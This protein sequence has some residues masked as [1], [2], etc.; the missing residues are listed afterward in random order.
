MKLQ[1]KT[2][3]DPNFMTIACNLQIKM[4]NKWLMDKIAESQHER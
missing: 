3:L 1:Q 2:R 4:N